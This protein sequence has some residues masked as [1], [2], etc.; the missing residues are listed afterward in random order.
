MAVPLA[1]H[2]PVRDLADNIATP[3]PM[4]LPPFI[5]DEVDET[6]EAVGRN[7][8]CVADVMSLLAGVAR[9]RA[10]AWTTRIP[11]IRW[12]PRIRRD[13]ADLVVGLCG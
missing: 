2:Q 10:D 5:L 1:I 3:R 12:I 8:I 9:L 13:S 11:P 6:I 7:P 4:G